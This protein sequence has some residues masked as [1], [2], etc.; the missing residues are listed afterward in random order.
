MWAFC[1]ALK[2]D[3]VNHCSEKEG[4]TE[5]Y[6]ALWWMSYNCRF[7]GVGK[8]Y[9]LCQRQVSGGEEEVSDGE[10]W[11]TDGSEWE[12]GWETDSEDEVQDE[13]LQTPAE[14]YNLKPTSISPDDATATAQTTKRALFAEGK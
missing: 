6:E 8:W 10:S 12:P 4:T 9:C 5:V 3:V 1:N 7:C 2:D 14:K 11:K 13:G